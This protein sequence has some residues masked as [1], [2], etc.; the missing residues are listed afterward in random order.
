METSELIQL[1]AE[2]NQLL[3][4]YHALVNKSSRYTRYDMI[5][6]IC[7]LLAEASLAGD[8]IARLLDLQTRSMEDEAQS[9][10][11]S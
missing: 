7:S 10:D 5:L 8:R 3:D 2:L 1:N 4:K 9:Q 6:H 11:K